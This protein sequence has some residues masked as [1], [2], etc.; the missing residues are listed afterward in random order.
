MSNDF[1]PFMAEAIKLATENVKSGKGGPFAAVIV[2]DN[3][4]IASGVNLVTST[5][6][7]TAHAEITAIR[8]ACKKL[9]SFQ[10]DECELYTSCEPCPMCLGAIYWARPKCVYYGNT[11]TDAAEY[12]FDDSFIYDEIHHLPVN[13]K[14]KMTQLMPAEAKVSFL[15]W[16][17]KTD[18]II[19]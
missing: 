10:L 2:K 6:D 3:K 15:E 14:I 11:K 13:R 8:N 19:Y 9:N 18:K 5:N 16:K 17:N 12:G 4:I 1:N 7:P